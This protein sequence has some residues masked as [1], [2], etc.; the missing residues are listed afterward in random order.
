V[1]G[2][3]KRVWLLVVPG[4]ELLD[5]SGPWAVLGHTNDVLGRAAYALELVGPA[6]PTVATLHGLQVTGVRP[7]PRTPTRL[8]DVAIVAGGSPFVPLPSPE[9]RVAA[10]LRR[11]HEKVGTLVSICT[12]A[13]VLGEAGILD[14]RR[15]T[16]HWRFLDALRARFT[17]TQ[18]V[19]EGIFVRDGHVWTSAGVTAG[20]D[21]TLA[22]VEQDH[23]HAVAMA[24]AKKL[25]LFLRRSGNQAQFSVALQRQAK[26]PS[27]LRH[28]TTFVLEHLDE[29]LPVE[30]LA[31]AAG[32]SVRTLT[33]WCRE[34]LDESPAEL[35][36][37]LRVEEAQRLLEDT[38]LPL[39]DISSRT[40]LGD[41]S[42]LWRVFTQRLGTTPAA[43]RERF[44]TNGS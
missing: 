36:R 15:A 40:G 28:I 11:H 21:L 22:M 17:A 24:V 4:A 44:A 25:V 2:A 33:R 6:S 14:G 3:V 41:A 32:A 43:Y 13:F 20:V 8:P 35:V 12:G 1:N 42:T 16:T 9:A 10:W 26:E 37:R 34:E 29:P 27:K 38:A 23:G 7:L 5:I 30:R 19:D 31:Q 39:K 18:V